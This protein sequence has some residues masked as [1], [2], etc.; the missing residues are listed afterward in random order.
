MEY[1]LLICIS[2]KKL[3]ALD[4]IDLDNIDRI[5]IEGNDFLE[6]KEESS[7]VEFSKYIKEYYNIDSFTDI[8]INICIVSFYAKRKDLN[9]IYK[10]MKDASRL[11]IIDAKVYL[12]ILLLKESSI[13]ANSIV[14]VYCFENSYIMKITSDLGIEYILEGNGDE[15]KLEPEMFSIIF[16]FTCD[17]LI[18]DEAEIR[19][20]K[21]NYKEL[22]NEYKSSI[23]KKDKEIEKY[24]DRYKKLELKY[25]NIIKEIEILKREKEE[26][27]KIKNTKRSVIWFTKDLIKSTSIYESNLRGEIF[28]LPLMAASAI[29]N[30]KEYKIRNLHKSGDIITKGTNITEIVEYVKT[31]IGELKETG[32]KCTIKAKYSGRIFYLK[33]NNVCVTNDVEIAIITDESDTKKDVMKWYKDMR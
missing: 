6:I 25:E 13:K 33:D 4:V 24:E 14:N 5:S 18:S 22:L 20:L 3:M 15:V 12:P 7:I 28:S 8:N 11:D 1:N 21:S 17:G 10:D 30:K 26:Q 16:M 19:K 2:E 29:V 27:N 9:L 23:E 32:R 31:S